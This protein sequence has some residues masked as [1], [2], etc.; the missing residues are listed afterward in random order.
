MAFLGQ[1]SVCSPKYGIP[2]RSV[3]DSIAL[4]LTSVTSYKTTGATNSSWFRVLGCGLSPPSQLPL[5]DKWQCN[6]FIFHNAVLQIYSLHHP[7]FLLTL[8][9][10]VFLHFWKSLFFRRKACIYKG[11]HKE[12]ACIGPSWAKEKSKCLSVLLL[13]HPEEVSVEHSYRKGALGDEVGMLNPSASRWG[14]NG[15]FRSRSQ[16]RHWQMPGPEAFTEPEICRK[17]SSQFSKESE[18]SGGPEPGDRI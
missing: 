18:R 3:Q 4:P 14:W 10:S 5:P 2:S 13:S 16:G 8:Q 1:T 17:P 6:S 11:E 9:S 7:F 12:T 15:I